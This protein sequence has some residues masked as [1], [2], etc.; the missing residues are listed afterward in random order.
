MVDKRRQHCICL[1]G[2]T[3]SRAAQAALARCSVSLWSVVIRLICSANMASR[4]GSV[5]INIRLM[6]TWSIC[7]CSIVNDC[8]GISV[9]TPDVPIRRGEFQYSRQRRVPTEITVGRFINRT[10]GDAAL[11]RQNQV[12]GSDSSSAR[13][14]VARSCLESSTSFSTLLSFV[15][16]SAICSSSSNVEGD[17]WAFPTGDIKTI[18]GP[19]P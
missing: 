14:S 13:S 4:S 18:V 16:A 15:N 7:R 19:L 8:S 6:R 11:E 10:F 2:R 5:S 12:A 9:I 3:V 17:I 1:G